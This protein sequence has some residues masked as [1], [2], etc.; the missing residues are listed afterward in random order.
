MSNSR[1]LIPSPRTKTTWVISSSSESIEADQISVLATAEVIAAVAMYWW[2]VSHFDWPWMAFI[3]LIA[4]PILLLRSPESIECGVAMLTQ[5]WETEKRIRSRL[6]V[7]STFAISVLTSGISIFWLFTSS[8]VNSASYWHL[9]LFLPI[10]FVYSLSIALLIASVFEGSGIKKSTGIWNNFVGSILGW[11][12]ATGIAI[13]LAKGFV[14]GL[15]AVLFV[16]LV[17]VFF[18]YIFMEVR[19]RSQIV[20]QITTLILAIFF[21]IGI[22]IRGLYIRWISTLIY[23]PIGLKYLP[24]NWRENLLVIDFLHP[25]ELLPKSGKV[26]PLF[27]VEKIS[28]AI[29]DM[30]LSSRCFGLIFIIALYIPALTYRWSLK[31]SAWLWWPLALALAPPFERLEYGQYREKTA[32]SVSGAERW[33]LIV[34]AVL[35]AWLIHS[36]LPDLNF[37]LNLLPEAA[38]NFTKGLVE[39]PTPPTFSVRNFALWIICI[40]SLIFWWKTKNLRAS[41]GKILESPSEFNGLTQNDEHRFR[42]LSQPIEKL[43]LLLIVTLLVLIEAYAVCFFNSVNPHLTHEIVSSWLLHIL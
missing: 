29:A 4:A 35:F 41:H 13:G 6:A 32:R 33:L 34:P 25:P 31:A 7:G 20:R 15:A 36:H 5:Y 21:V 9:I 38:T 8:L 24:Q 26:S 37:I 11:V 19:K 23:L 22:L 10:A 12:I 2:A 43:R 3:G 18:T 1:P 39:L 16:V 28:L 42:Q 30:D 27:T 40:L 14:M 17:S